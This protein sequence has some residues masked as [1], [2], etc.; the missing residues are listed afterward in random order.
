ML[1]DPGDRVSNGARDTC[2]G[3]FRR[4]GGPPFTT[5]EAECSRELCNQEFAFGLRLGSPLVV[6]SG[7]GLLDVVV[8]LDEAPAVGL[9]GLRV[10]DLA[11]VAER[12]VR[13]SGR[14][15]GG[16]RS[17]VAALGGHQIQD[18][19]L[20]AR[21][22]EKPCHIAHALEVAHANGLTVVDHRPVVALATEEVVRFDRLTGSWLVVLQ[23]DRH[24]SGTQL[25]KDRAGRIALQCGP[26]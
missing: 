17:A 11:R 12:P 13:Q 20:P 22:S 3:T 19:V 21:L 26:V 18:V 16:G 8:D 9:L 1:T 5:T 23:R 14:T 15:A 7:A 2:S 4:G 25:V 24:G 6:P 10:D